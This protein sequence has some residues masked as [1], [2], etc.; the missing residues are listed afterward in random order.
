LARERGVTVFG[1]FWTHE[2][3]KSLRQLGIR[4]ERITATATFYHVPDLHD[5]SRGVTEEVTGEL[6]RRAG[7]QSSKLN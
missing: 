3:G 5:F 6:F 7:R 1:Q 4:P 2:T